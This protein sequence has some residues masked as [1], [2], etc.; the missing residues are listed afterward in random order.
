MK[1]YIIILICCSAAIAPFPTGLL[2]IDAP[3][4][5]TRFTV[6]GYDR[7]RAFG[8]GWAQ[9]PGGCD[10]RQ[11][12]MAEAWAQPCAVPYTQWGAA[13]ISDPYT[14]ED[15]LPSDVEL[16]HLY[17]LAAAWDMGAHAWPQE[18]RL[19]FANDPLNLVVTSSRANQAK[20]DSLPSEWMPPARRNRCA[21]SR[22]LAQVAAKY[23]LALP[24]ADR[25]V[26]RRS[27]AGLR[28]L[29]SSSVW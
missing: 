29:T 18:K 11:I 1:R 28:G 24:R 15:L 2:L 4:A 21:Y 19:A 14:N 6:T 20:S 22:R 5:Q 25:K 9:G 27:C 17:P 8:P 26:M 12:A 3:V 10:S 23:E 13:P 16:D 7:Q